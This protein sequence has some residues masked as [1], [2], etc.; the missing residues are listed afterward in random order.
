LFGGGALVRLLDTLLARPTLVWTASIVAAKASM[1]PR[2]ARRAL[3]R[4]RALGVVAVDKEFGVLALNV[5]N[6]VV[7]ALLRFHEA[8]AACEAPERAAD[9]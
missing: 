9:G 2:S 5:D 7:Q 6:P 3:S 8:L 4:L 1:D